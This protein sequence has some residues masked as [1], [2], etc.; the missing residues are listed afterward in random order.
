MVV[1]AIRVPARRDRPTMQREIRFTE[2]A[3]NALHLAQKEGIRL[4]HVSIGT[5][6]MLLGLLS[7][8]ESVAIE[9]F[10]TLNIPL[11]RLRAT[12][13]HSIADDRTEGT[14]ELQVGERNGLTSGA[15]KAIEFAGDEARRFGHH[16]IDTEHLL[17]G[18]MREGEGIV[19]R[20]LEE[21]IP[22]TETVR[23][24]IIT[25][26]S[27][28]NI[29]APRLVG[30]PT[31]DRFGRAVMI[32]ARLGQQ[33]LSVG[34]RTQIDQA[35]RILCRLS[36]RNPVLIGGSDTAKAAIMDGIATRMANG[37]VP[38]VLGNKR[39]VF[40]DAAALIRTYT[41]ST[42]IEIITA[43]ADELRDTETCILFIDTIHALLAD[44]AAP[45][46]ATGIAHIFKDVLSR[47]DIHCIGVTTSDNYRVRFEGDT[48]LMRQFRLVTVPELGVDATIRI[49]QAMRQD[50]ENHHHLRISDPALVAAAELAD[51]YIESRTMPDTAIDVL[52][53]AAAH[54]LVQLSNQRGALAKAIDQVEQADGGRETNGSGDDTLASDDGAVVVARLQ[55][56]ERELREKITA[57]TAQAGTEQELVVT[58]DDIAE[59]VALRNGVLPAQVWPEAERMLLQTSLIG[60]PPVGISVGDVGAMPTT[61]STSA[62]D[63]I[64]VFVSYSHKDRRLKDELVEHLSALHRQGV[65]ATWHDGKIDAGTEWRPEIETHLNRA[66]VILL[67]ISRSF[68]ASEFCYSI[69]MTRAVERHDVG[70]ARVIPIILRPSDWEDAPFA[71]LQALP[72]HGRPIVLWPNRDSAWLNVTGGIRKAVASLRDSAAGPTDT[73]ISGA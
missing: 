3:H 11:D 5:E 68:M 22:D 31:V 52:D 57:L 16:Y 67:L 43:M 70:E 10:A 32:D 7:Q 69:E 35:I 20:V 55:E 12:I 27:R 15:K 71:K 21:T 59:I 4:G 19:A 60:D 65:I 62:T 39:L 28:P 56:R 49:L 33:S 72:E 17:L 1:T 54:V 13:E 30:T 34:W 9:V 24:H 46:Q 14:T 42:V 63:A 37:D 6:H 36:G 25:V 8:N 2:R 50:Y 58:E 26:L 45:E 23:S 73:S 48:T 47:G 51:R 41:A 64:E 53:D 40:L 29:P 18:I 61:K 66:R 38:E 44:A